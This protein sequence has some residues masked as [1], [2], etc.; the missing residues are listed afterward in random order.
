MSFLFFIISLLSILV[1]NLSYYAGYIKKTAT[2]IGSCSPTSES[3]PIKINE[4]SE[5][6]GNFQVRLPINKT[7]CDS[8]I[9]GQEITVYYKSG[10]IP[11][12]V[13]VDAK[14]G[15]KIAINI[16]LSISLVISGG[17]LGLSVFS[18]MYG[19]VKNRQVVDLGSK[20]IRLLSNIVDKASAI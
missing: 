5:T 15:L 6:S 14:S 20:S 17:I 19:I 7:R 10:N 2:V 4:S 8:Y 9:N 12:T 11:S 13:T 16:A 18:F 3:V 1:L